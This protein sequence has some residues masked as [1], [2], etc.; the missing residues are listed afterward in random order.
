MTSVDE[1]N[2]IIKLAQDGD[3]MSLNKL[4]ELSAERLRGYVYRLVM[5]DNATKDIIQESV[6]QMLKILKELKN[7]ERFWPWLY[8]IALNKTHRYQR[9]QKQQD[10]IAGAYLKTKPD[11]SN[12]LEK[13]IND[14]MKELVTASMAKL[15][16]RHRA[17]LA[18]RC[19]EKMSY[20]E[21]SDSLGCSRVAA[22]M[23]FARAKHSLARQLSR[24]GLSKGAL[25]TALVLFGKMTAPSQAA[26]AKIAVTSAT[27][28]VSAPFTVAAV[29]TTKAM[30]TT[31]AA[32]GIITSTAIVC[33]TTDKDTT[34]TGNTIKNSSLITIADTED[35][36]EIGEFWY[37]YPDAPDGPVMLRTGKDT[38]NCTADYQWLL[39][40]DG[41][42]RYNT[43]KNIVEKINHKIFH[44]DFCVWQLPT[45][46]PAMKRFISQQQ[47]TKISSEYTPVAGGGW[48]VIINSGEDG[49]QYRS[50][51]HYNVLDEEYFRY[52]WPK[53]TK[54]VDQRDQMHKRGWTYFKIEGQVN[55]V[56]VKGKGR[57][58]LLYSKS[59]RY[60]PW[61]KINI[62]SKSVTDKQGKF[63]FRGLAKPYMG[64]HT[65]DII[66]RDA[67][68]QNLP[69]ETQVSKDKQ[70]AI[71][72]ISSEEDKL[73][74][75]IDIYNDL[76]EQIELD[77]ARSGL[78]KF[79]YLQQVDNLHSQFKAPVRNKSLNGY[80]KLNV[81]FFNLFKCALED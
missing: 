74:Y 9:S 70:K 25:L 68:K 6:L 1:L 48:L 35:E 34:R 77:G 8:H 39:N 59:K 32:I 60:Y 45:D 33:K 65:I 43:K 52:N 40:A 56:P 51:R 7:T 42:Y 30:L 47:G 71:I 19:Y 13:M 21:I 73:V 44:N 53:G 22:R 20:Q 69:F 26:A 50:T 64:L 12:S 38:E 3:K 58:P 72:T 31:I 46:G 75:T 37:Y 14:E 62:S 55:N 66:R 63:L 15:K 4:S 10:R 28:K 61:L 23:L 16:T 57:V 18:M 36:N 80:T 41:N 27:I 29:L 54:I 11:S 76:I 67:A 2:Q 81:T 24:H 5:N 79:E 49:P 17:V 78:L